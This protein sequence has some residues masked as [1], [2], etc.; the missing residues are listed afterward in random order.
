MAIARAGADKVAIEGAARTF[1][2]FSDIEDQCE[3][4]YGE[5]L[6]VLHE[7]E[8]FE[9]VSLERQEEL[10][11]QIKQAIGDGQRKLVDDLVD[12]LSRHTWLHQ[13]AAF[14]LGMAVGLR[15]ALGRRQ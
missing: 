13:E 3:D 14:H 8:L 9:P 12:N 10:V 1:P 11:K 7:D 5:L 4:E 2:S 15:I 6:D